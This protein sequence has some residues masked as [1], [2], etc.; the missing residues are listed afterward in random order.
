MLQKIF[1]YKVELVEHSEEYTLVRADRAVSVGS[2]I[3]VK[4][5]GANGQR[6]PAVPMVVV[7]CRECEEGYLVTGRF[8]VEHPDLSGLEIPTGLGGDPSMRASAR[9]NCH[10]CVISRDLPGYR[11]ITI[12][13]SE[14]GLQVEAPARVALGNSVLLR[15][16]FD[17]EK[18]P[19]V[20]ASATVAWCSKLERGRYRIGLKFKNLDERSKE[21]IKIYRELLDRRAE[22]DIAQKTLRDVELDDVV[23]IG[24]FAAT[25]LQVLNWHDIP[26]KPSAILMG[27]RRQGG[28]LDVRLQGGESG[29][30]CYDFVFTEMRALKDSL[31]ADVSTRPVVGL[32]FA[33]LADGYFRFQFLDEEKTPMLE[34]EAQGCTQHFPV[35]N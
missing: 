1:G 10:L 13:I 4:V 30:R 27:Y 3:P 35:E 28:R 5:S 2:Q 34:I 24:Q 20:E 18:L 6:T 23:E 12:D 17:T 8:L 16:E 26:I 29:V 11:A 19:A 14:G 33:E 7:S 25:T 15:V 9:V 32:R 31:D 21:V 22:V